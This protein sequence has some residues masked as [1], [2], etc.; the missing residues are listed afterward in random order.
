MR[1]YQFFIHSLVI[2]PWYTYDVNEP[3][4]ENPVIAGKYV[5]GSVLYAGRA[6]YG[7][8]LLPAMIFINHLEHGTIAHV[9]YNGREI[10]QENGFEILLP[11]GLYVWR[12]EANGGVPF[13]AIEVGHT[14]DG[15]TLYLGRGRH[16]GAVIPG[17][18]HPTHNCLYIPFG[19]REI[20]L[21]QYEV[22]C[23]R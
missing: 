14:A 11:D 5:D 17:K 6:Y 4:P 1:N 13:R 7:G 18:V 10:P 12:N 19:G 20:A 22:L 8:D 15:E 2:K 3:L 9:S 21:R 23:D 16:Q